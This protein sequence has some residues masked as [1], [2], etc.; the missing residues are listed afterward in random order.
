METYRDQRF[1]YCLH[2]GYAL[3]GLPE[4][5]T[6]CPECG[7]SVRGESAVPNA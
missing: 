1:P 7:E 2:C 3:K 4:E 5:Q 6:T